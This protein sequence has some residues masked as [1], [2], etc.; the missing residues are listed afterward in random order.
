VVVAP[1]ST[2]PV[3]AA[4]A[5]APAPVRTVREAFKARQQLPAAPSTPTA[6]GGDVPM[7]AEPQ[8]EQQQPPA[9]R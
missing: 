4:S 7:S 8:Q 3:A 9:A 1:T 2:A 6:A 5:A